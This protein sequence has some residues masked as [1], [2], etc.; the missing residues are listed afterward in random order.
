MNNPA[1]HNL[2]D[3]TLRAEDGEIVIESSSGEVLSRIEGVLSSE[4][5]NI[6]PEESPTVDFEIQDGT[7]II[8]TPDNEIDV[9]GAKIQNIDRQ[10]QVQVQDI[11]TLYEE[12]PPEQQDS[13]FE[14]YVVVEDDYVKPLQE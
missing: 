3:V 7:L 6:G 13:T 11:P 14:A 5:I 4:E 9:D 10:D 12:Y 2:D 8:R 1:R